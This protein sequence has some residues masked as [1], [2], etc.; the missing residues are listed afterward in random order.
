MKKI[1]AQFAT[2]VIPEVTANNE[3]AKDILNDD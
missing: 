3:F 2:K 1:S